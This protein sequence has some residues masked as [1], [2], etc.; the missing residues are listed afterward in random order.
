MY[1]VYNPFYVT[2]L[3]YTHSLDHT[4]TEL[5]EAVVHVHHPRQ[6]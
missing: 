5:E 2:H 4:S 3:T 6:H 1:C